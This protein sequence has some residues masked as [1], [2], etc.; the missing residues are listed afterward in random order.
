[1]EEFSRR[2]LIALT[3]GAA[4]P[5]AALLTLLLLGPT[6][7]AASVPGTE[8]GIV[9]TQGNVLVGVLIG[10]MLSGIVAYTLGAAA[11]LV[12]FTATHCPRPH[13][14]WI[15]C[16]ALSPVWMAALLTLDLDM[17]GFLVLSGAL[18]AVVRL[19]FGFLRLPRSL[20]SDL[21]PGSS[22]FG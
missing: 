2:V 4:G 12:A 7:V 15:I 5:A 1:M 17:A 6:L 16:L 21:M 8:G 3:V 18:P 11:T 9:E 13:L 10:G 14:A 22:E 20:A 19:G